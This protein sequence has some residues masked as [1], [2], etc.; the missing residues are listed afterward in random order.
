M[1]SL[2]MATTR[3]PFGKHRSPGGDSPANVENERDATICATHSAAD[4]S[5]LPGVGLAEST[6]AL[7][8]ATRRL[9]GALRDDM[10]LRTSCSRILRARPEYRRA[11]GNASIGG[12]RSIVAGAAIDRD[13]SA[14]LPL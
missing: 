11:V 9:R 5:Q 7:P 14:H 12:H 8:D 4:R 3:A 2:L 1:A 13:R 10:S 6:R